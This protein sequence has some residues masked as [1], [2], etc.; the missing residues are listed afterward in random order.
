MT[1]LGI[2]SINRQVMNVTEPACDQC[3]KLRST[4]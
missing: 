4:T 2:E 3:G 1:S